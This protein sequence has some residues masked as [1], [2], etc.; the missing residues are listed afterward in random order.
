M[1]QLESARKG[2]VT[3][4]MNVVAEAEGL[5]VE[6]IREGVASGRIVIP[7]NI[8]HENL[9]PCGIGSPRC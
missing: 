9:V 2:I 4:E 1:T 3:P 7:A 5:D 6:F 8:N